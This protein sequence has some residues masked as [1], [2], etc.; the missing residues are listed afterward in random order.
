MEALNLRELVEK[1]RRYKNRLGGLLC[2]SLC[3]SEFPIFLG[4]GFTTRDYMRLNP[5]SEPSSI[6][7]FEALA[8]VIKGESGSFAVKNS[9]LV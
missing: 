4:E 7:E 2:H 9:V 6:S 8:F 5:C 1:L 3:D